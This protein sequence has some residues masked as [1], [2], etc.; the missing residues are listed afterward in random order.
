MKTSIG[1]MIT[2]ACIIVLGLGCTSQT[3]T[4]NLSRGV[5]ACDKH[6]GLS[7]MYWTP[8]HYVAYCNDGKKAIGK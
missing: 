2:G 7:R 5:S 8:D 1:L 4:N 6:E 3:Q